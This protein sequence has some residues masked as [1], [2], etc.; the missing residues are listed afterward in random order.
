M[1]V[2]PKP[3]RATVSVCPTPAPTPTP[4]STCTRRRP[5]PYSTRRRSTQRVNAPAP[6]PHPIH[7]FDQLPW[8]SALDAPLNP[9]VDLADLSQLPIPEPPSSPSVRPQHNVNRKPPRF[10]PRSPPCDTPAPAP[11][12]ALP[13]FPLRTA[14]SRPSTP[15]SRFI[16]ARVLFHNLM[17]VLCESPLND[18]HCTSSPNSSPTTSSLQPSFFQLLSPRLA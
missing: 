15:L 5:K 16:P 3:R 8:I 7:P 11:A 4:R 9:L 18:A 2:C 13:P 6:A 17:P 12:P 14:P 1:P 10:R